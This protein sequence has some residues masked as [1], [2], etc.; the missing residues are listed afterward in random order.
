MLVGGTRSTP[1]RHQ[2]LRATLDW[3]HDLLDAEERAVFRRL[4]VFAGGFTLASAERVAVGGD[5]ARQQMLDLLTR[6]ADKSLLHVDQSGPTA[7][8]QLLSTVREYA[9]ERL[10]DAGEE[11]AA[12]R[13]HLTRMAELVGEITPRIDR[14]SDGA[15]GLE[16]ELDALD[17][18]TGNLRAAMELARQCN[19]AIAAL[20]IAGPLGKYAYL[21]GHY[22]EVRQWMD[23]AV[24]LGPDAPADLRAVALLGT[25][26][27][28]LLQCDYQP[29]VRRLEAALRLYRELDDPR[30]IAATLQVLGSVAREQGR[31]ARATDLQAESLATAT[32][33]DDQ[34]AVASRLSRLR[35]LAAARL[36]P[37]DERMQPGACTVARA[38]RRRRHG[39][40]AD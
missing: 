28:A 36:R 27:L 3:S 22:Q 6:L 1:R 30:G 26:R 5:I 38:R 25:G 19:D 8:Y 32:A 35:R 20:R 21:R 39:V 15:D 12:R 23:A 14:G 13:A 4:A 10:A 7:R 18:E 33:A 29:A 31:Y 11:D 9:R 16:R 37:G 34:W 17:A 2:A 40:G 24:I